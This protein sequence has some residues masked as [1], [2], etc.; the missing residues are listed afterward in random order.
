MVGKSGTKH[1]ILGKWKNV[2]FN[3]EQIVLQFFLYLGILHGTNILI[4]LAAGSYVEQ[5]QP[6][7]KDC[8]V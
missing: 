5:L 7:W 3:S 1:K 2:M 4:G 8:G 6:T